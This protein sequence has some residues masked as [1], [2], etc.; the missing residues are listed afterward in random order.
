MDARCSREIGFVAGGP[1]LETFFD[2][3]PEDELQL[4]ACAE[5]AFM[6]E[7]PSPDIK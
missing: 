3:L 2:E 5:A 7:G 6:A 1:I 4:W